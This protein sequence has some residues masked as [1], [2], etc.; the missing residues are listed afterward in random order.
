[1]AHATAAQWLERHDA[2][3]IAQLV[4]DDNVEISRIDLQTDEVVLALLDDA[5]G[6][7]DVALKSAGRYSDTNL[8]GLTG[9][10]LNHRVRICCDIAMSLAFD[11]RP[12]FEPEIA[13]RHH[14][15][16]AELLEKLRTG[17]NIFDLPAHQTAS[18]PT[19]DGPTSV[20]YKRNNLL[21]DR[22]HRFFPGRS[23]RLPTDRG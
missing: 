17:A 10:M 1:M 23:Q 13:D 9:S 21:V 20:D 12:G 5:T 15:K 22:S 7:M 19:L 14:A 16:A 8:S 3:M 11:R 6:E 4:G 2:R 18:N